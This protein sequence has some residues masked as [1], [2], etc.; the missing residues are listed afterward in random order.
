MNHWTQ[1][2]CGL[3]FLALA[4][5]G[6]GGGSAGGVSP[7]APV[8]APAPPPPARTVGGT[9]TGLEGSVVLQNNGAGNLTV[10]ANGA[11][12]FADSVND[13]GTYN[14]TVLTQPDHRQCTVA[15]GQGTA[16]ANV[17]SVTVSCVYAD[18]RQWGTP[19][20]LQV[21]TEHGFPEATRM[22]MGSDG[23]ILASVY[24]NF[25]AT[26]DAISLWA[27][28]FDPA[29]R[30][31]STP[32]QLTA[33]GNTTSIFY[34]P[35]IATS[36][37]GDV[38][39]WQQPNLVQ[40]RSRAAGGDW[41][42]AAWSGEPRAELGGDLGSVALADGTL[43]VVW[44]DYAPA[45]SPQ[46]ILNYRILRQ[47]NWSDVRLASDQVLSSG[48]FQLGTDGT[49]AFVIWEAPG[50]AL[51]SCILGDQGCEQTAVVQPATAGLD[52]E[53][54]EVRADGVA[55]AVWRTNSTFHAHIRQ[56][57]GW[58]GPTDLGTRAGASTVALVGTASLPN[59]FLVLGK[60]DDKLWARRYGTS[61]GSWTELGPLVSNDWPAIAVDT[62]GNVLVTWIMTDELAASS[63]PVLFN[64]F[65]AGL[66]QWTGHGTVAANA[67]DSTDVL[68]AVDSR[69]NVIAAWHGVIGTNMILTTRLFDATDEAW[70]DPVEHAVNGLGP[71]VFFDSQDRGV[72]AWY[73]NE[74]G[75]WSA[76]S[77]ARA[78]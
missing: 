31:W 16:S 35:A 51:Q 30:S 26:P 12:T 41:T 77:F 53:P 40:V 37:Q 46:F 70:R 48:S 22:V 3:T 60:A 67:Y 66:G 71:G 61:W 72:L 76:N 50:P 49:R 68:A 55:M 23:L 56:A 14:V 75:R 59:G 18:H 1:S 11:F 10:S 28:D 73:D 7:P 33:P 69:G 74:S 13:G 39:A 64:R 5:C 24:R 20:A 62:L 36:S 27:G 63:Y 4:A 6:G 8:P 29:A 9:L 21:P 44:R 58:N 57:N 78:P 17:T 38:L 15:N 45:R 32:I 47:G 34:L 2:A 19:A 42:T 54:F 25:Q 43:Y 52:I 65:D